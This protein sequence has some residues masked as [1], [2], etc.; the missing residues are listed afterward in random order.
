MK[1]LKRILGWLGFRWWR[2]T[3]QYDSPHYTY[4]AN[5]AGVIRWRH[6]VCRLSGKMRRQSRNG[7]GWK[8][9]KSFKG[10]T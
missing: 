2:T 7:R 1:M 6:Q 9:D 3:H 5:P 10:L 8:T 4:P